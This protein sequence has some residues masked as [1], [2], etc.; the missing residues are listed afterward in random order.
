[1]GRGRWVVNAVK[2]R[3]NRDRYGFL[4]PRRKKGTVDGP[5]SSDDAKYLKEKEREGRGRAHASKEANNLGR[6]GTKM[7]RNWGG[8]GLEEIL[9]LRLLASNQRR[10]GRRERGRSEARGYA[11][12][13]SHP[14]KQ[15]LRRG[16]FRVTSSLYRSIPYEREEENNGYH[17]LE[18]RNSP[19]MA[20]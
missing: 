16:S 10:R 11:K 1:L 8:R 12:G 17:L 3:K 18:A 4:S 2:D 9:F 14:W 13:I 15:N 20:V 19:K 7:K 6:W 5:G